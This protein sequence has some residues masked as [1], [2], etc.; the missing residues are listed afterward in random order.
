MTV[1]GVTTTYSYHNGLL[2]S[3]K[4]GDETL[5]YYYDNS[6]K[7]LSLGY[8]KGTAEETKYFFTRNAQDDIVSIYR[9]MVIIGY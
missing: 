9:R 2:I 3:E 5:R 1:N 7:V 6:G 8:I 4:T